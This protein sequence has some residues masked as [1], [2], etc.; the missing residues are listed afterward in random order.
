MLS[1]YFPLRALRFLF[2]FA[3]DTAPIGIY[4][5]VDI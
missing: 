5:Q 1:Y 3:F 4:Q 2:F